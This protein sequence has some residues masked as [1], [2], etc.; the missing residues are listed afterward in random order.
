MR[1]FT[2]IVL[3]AVVAIGGMTSDAMAQRAESA[4]KQSYMTAFGRQAQD[5]EVKYWMGRQDWQNAD[6]LVR[7]HMDYVKTNAGA[8]QQM[9]DLAFAQ[10]GVAKPSQPTSDYWKKSL[11]AQPRKYSDLLN[12]VRRWTDSRT[13]MISGSYWE[14]IGRNPSA[15]EVGYWQTRMDY[16]SQADLVKL[17]I[18]GIKTN[19]ALGDEAIN[20]SYKKVFSRM[21]NSGELNHWRQHA[22]LGWT[23]A[24]MAVE[25]EKWKNSVPPKVKNNTKLTDAMKKQNIFL[26]TNNNL[27]KVPADKV[28]KSIVPGS[29]GK[30]VAAGAGNVIAP[31]GGYLIGQDGASIV[32]AGGGNIVAAGGG[33]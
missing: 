8:Q 26:D 30:I 29:G 23:S 9:I 15:G 14:A 27:V 21:P 13:R 18:Q 31:V 6:N 17:H 24:Q 32:A 10:V 3:V 28:A 33:N 7:F 2:W 5:G 22:K 4:V 20:N 19:Q 25:H 11:S 12:D 1:C 16:N